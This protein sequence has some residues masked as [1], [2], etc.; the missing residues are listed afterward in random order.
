MIQGFK[1]FMSAAAL[2]AAMLSGC[3]AGNEPETVRYSLT[4]DVAA[5]SLSSPYK[6]TV[7]L[8]GELKDGGLAVRTS[9]VTV[10]P[11]VHHV[12]SGG[13][14]SQL[15]VLLADAMHQAGVGSDVSV[16]ARIYKFEGSLNGET[17]IEAVIAASRSGKTI[18]RQGFSY[19]GRQSRQ[20][21]APMAEDLGKGFRGIAAQAASIMASR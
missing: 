10:R 21:Y 14:D 17:S 16:D 20:G 9:D 5:S 8:F 13:L 15:E 19:S 2:A 18:L 12:W 6:I 7:S 3:T 11:A 1:A 4:S